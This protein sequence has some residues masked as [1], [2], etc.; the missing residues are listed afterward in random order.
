[1]TDN[2]S[3]ASLFPSADT[4]NKFSTVAQLSIGLAQ[5]AY[6]RQIWAAYNAAPT[7]YLPSVQSSL[8]RINRQIEEGSFAAI[9]AGTRSARI[10][11][12]AT[13]ADRIGVAARPFGGAIMLGENAYDLATY[14]GP[15]RVTRAVGIAADDAVGVLAG[16][17]TVV[18]Y[19]AVFG[20]PAGWAALGI[21]A[22][23]AGAYG[24]WGGDTVRNGV[25]GFLDNPSVPLA[26]MTPMP[27]VDLSRYY[28]A[29]D[30]PSA[31]FPGKF[32][33][34]LGIGAP[35][36]VGGLRSASTPSYGGPGFDGAYGGSYGGQDEGS[37][38][39][40]AQSL[41]AGAY[42][43]PASG[44]PSAS[45]YNYDGSPAYSYSNPYSNSYTA[46]V[47]SPTL[48]LGLGTPTDFA[49]AVGQPAKWATADVY[50]TASLTGLYSGAVSAPRVQPQPAPVAPVQPQYAPLPYY[51]PVPADR[52]SNFSQAIGQ[53]APAL[54][55]FAAGFAPTLGAAA[56]GFFSGIA[57]VVGAFVHDAFGGSS[58]GKTKPVLLDLDGNG[59]SVDTLASSN[60]FLDLD[61]SG[62]MRRTA[63]AGK[64][65]GVL[66][67]DADDNGK[68]SSSKEFAFTE[69]DP[70]ANGD[71]EAL[72]N[73]FDTNANGKLDAG[74]AQWAKFKVMV[75]GQMVSLS[76]L[77]VT[78][79][80]LTAKGSGQ[81]FSDGSAITGTTTFTKSDGTTG[82]VGDAVLSNETDSHVVKNTVVVNADQ[83]STRT[84]V[85]YNADGTLAF[86]SL[87][88]TSADG[89][90]VQ[91][92]FDDDGNG[93][94]DRS[95]TD[96]TTVAAS[97]ERTRVISN[98]N[99]DGSLVERTTTVTS[100]DLKT[101]TTSV[102]N[103][104]DGRDDQTQTFATNADGS[105]MTTTKEFSTSGALLQQKLVQSSADGLT[106]TT[107]TDANGDGVYEAV[108]TETTVIA[109]DGSRTRTVN[110]TSANGT[111]L[112]S[113]TTLTS[114]DGRT[115]T[116]S[117][118]LDGNGTLDD[119]EQTQR[120]IAANGDVTT[121]VTTTNGNGS[122][123]GKVTTVAAADGLS[124]TVSTDLTSDGV[125]DRV[126]SDVTLVAGDGTRTQTVQDTSASGVVLSKSFTTTSVDGKVK[127]ISVD[128]NGDGA[129]DT[130]TTITVASD[131]STSQIDSTLS[132]NGTLVSKALT[133]TSA[134]G[135]SKILSTDLNGDGSFDTV[136]TD[137]ITAGTSG[138]RIETVTRKSANGALIGQTVT[139]TSADSLTQTVQSDRNGDGTFDQTVTDVVTLNA[140]AR[141]ETVTAKSGN[142]T[143]LSQTVTTVSADRKTTSVTKDSDGDGHIDTA[144]T[145]I[146]AADGSQTTTT[147]QGSADGSLHRKT[148]VTVSAD[149]LTTTTTDD[150]NGDGT[151]DVTTVDQTVINADGS[152]TET[153]TDKS[154]TGVLLDKATTVTSGNGLT[155]TVQKDINGDG[156]VDTK[157]VKATVLN[158]DGSKTT[159]TS[160]YAGTALTDQTKVTVSANG[161]V[162]T[163]SYDYDGNATVDRTETA[164]KTL[165][166]D[167]S[168]SLVDAVSTA[169]GT[170]LSKTTNTATADG[171]SLTNQ[172]DLDGDGKIDQKTT[173]VID[174][175]GLTTKTVETY[176]TGT[177]TLASRSVTTTST[178]GLSVM[179]KSD[180]DGDGTFEQALSDVTALNAD[181]SRTET[182]VR[183]TNT[184]SVELTKVTTSANGLIKT[185]VVSDDLIGSA[186]R[187]EIY[188]LYHAILGRDPDASGFQNFS[189]DFNNGVSAVTIA[190]NLLNS[191]EFAQKYGTLTNIQF[192]TLLYQNALGRAPEPGAAEG[193]DAQIKAGTS[194]A[195][196]AQE[197]ADSPEG[198]AHT[199]AGVQA[200]ALNNPGIVLS[201]VRTTTDVTTLGADGSTTEVVTNTGVISNKT[202]T[203]TS[204]DGKTVTVTYDIDGNGVVDQKSVTT[205]NADGSVTQT[206]SDLTSAGAVS[207]SKTV[208]TGAGGF[209]TL[210]S[211]DTDGNGAANKTVS[212]LTTLNADGSKTTVEKTYAL[213]GSGTLVLS[214]TTQT[215]TSADGLTV[216]TKW[217]QTGSGTFT[218]SRTDVTVLNADGSRTETVSYFT[219]TTLTSRYLTKTS[220]EGLSVTTLSDPAGTGVYAQ[221]LKDVTVVNADGTRTRT[222]TSTRSDGS[223]ISTI[224]T[225]TSADGRLLSTNEQR[226][227]LATQTVSDRV[228]MLADGAKRE[229]VTTTDTSGK[230]IDKTIT[231]TS[232]DKQTVTIDRDA[233]GDSVIDQHQQTMTADSG[234]VTQTVTNYKS[235]GVK[236]DGSTSTTT[237]DGLQS[238]TNWD[239]DGNG[240]VDRRRVTVNTNNADG[241]KT[242]VIAD[243]DL[244]TN[245]LASKT[246]IQQS[247]DGMVRTTSKDVDGDG[248]VDQV[249]TLTADTT[250][251]TISIVTNNAIG[252]KADY[253]LAGQ[254]YW[255]QAIAA[256]VETDSSA[257]GRT[258][259]VK[260]DYD[261]NGTFEVVMQSQLQADGSTVATVTETNASGGVIAKGTITTS[262]DGLITVLAKDSTNDGVIDHTETSVIHN[263]GS[264]TLTKVDLN[265]SSA[266]TQTVVDTVSAMG[267]LTLRVTSDGQGRKISQL[268]IAGDG[269]SVTTNYNAAGAQ[270]TS[271]IN[272]NKAGTPTSAVLYDPL[273][274]N[275]WARVEQSFDANG[276]KTFERQF[277][278]DGTRTEVTFYTPTGAQQHVDFFNAA[279]IRTGSIDYDVT[280]SQPWNR[281][282][283][284]FNAAGQ[285]LTE[286]TYIDD[287]SHTVHSFDPTNSQP[288]ANIDQEYNAAGKITLVWQNNDDGTYSVDTYDAGNTAN[289]SR[290]IKYYDAAGR[291]FQEN[292]YMDDGSSGVYNFDVSNTQSW[293]RYAQHFN[294]AGQADYTEQNNDDGSHTT[295][296]YDPTN[297]QSWNRLDQNFNT[298]GQLVSQVAYYDNGT[299]GIWFWDPTNAQSW[300]EIDQSFNTAGQMTNQNVIYDD[301]SKAL[302]A[303]DPGNTQSWSQIVDAYTSSGKLI[304]DTNYSDTNG[305]YTVTTYDVNNN[306]PWTR[307]VQNFVNNVINTATSYND[308]GGYTNYQYDS[309][310]KN[311]AW[312]R[313]AYGTG[314][315]GGSSGLHMVDQWPQAGS[316][317]GGHRPVLLDLNGDGHID[318]RPLDTNALATG[319]SVTFDWNGDGARDGTAWVG[320]Q[321]GFLAI[322]LGEDGQAGWDGKI[323]QSKELA[324]SEWA[325]P[326]QVAASGGSVSDL[327]GLRLAFD[328][329]H[330]NV[331]DASDDRWSEFRVWRDAN[332][333]GAVD[334]GELQTMSEAG[335][336]L[337]N[338]LSTTDSSQSFSD[339]SAITGTSS[340]QTS[341]GASHYLVGDST[342]A[343]QPAIPK[344]NA[345]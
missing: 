177:T 120:T 27:N 103:D 12:L 301:G 181:G 338:L 8:P 337:I 132:T 156:T 172:V 86:Q 195:A 255:K 199:A 248:S 153:V 295:I 291:M 15:S 182:L 14:Q 69:W 85:G 162:T 183:S 94:Y 99:A 33:D 289:W 164:T 45:K 188:R 244:T 102:D 345:A 106:K 240:T 122:L 7:R 226:T 3:S 127:T 269:S 200:W 252:Q 34:D 64:G 277:N 317:G 328:T 61:N 101:I 117:S 273:N 285:L 239:L 97:G 230:L 115:R 300:T 257:D 9:A 24:W 208:T 104:G 29:V 315:G 306:Q 105:S 336:K 215:D 342:L 324:F 92:K 23:G 192:A 197:I 79:I 125:A 253:L 74:D 293:W 1:M 292:D 326:D 129:A 222:Q 221:M 39:R 270:V 223:V 210:V 311:T 246:T 187:S 75:D 232:A 296:T 335:I 229:T 206:S 216:T 251:A 20:T 87:V 154:N 178:N 316:G 60:T 57:G 22:L 166:T 264:I 219:G 290:I 143:L 167:G 234:V 88:A 146:I 287:G 297:A 124:T 121:V 138:A 334:D 78:S 98:F 214:A 95:Q 80:D 139:T 224:M 310:G 65:D 37:R 170:L 119:Q 108:T 281:K 256:K 205:K 19:G 243:T 333:N 83:T 207:H 151:I 161:L 238:T 130:L 209:N 53:F 10:A 174:A 271:V 312:Q 201:P 40:A 48:G 198:Q 298:N 21:G 218:K 343:Y 241:S 51:G 202:T 111:L 320:P 58:S 113:D 126:H 109:S 235:A 258:K 31:P 43:S 176:K 299:K 135:L 193:R 278:D 330:D 242:T 150:L 329:N 81:T 175:T 307:L 190:A 41:G 314:G 4:V 30:G 16:I 159:T 184:A 185:T 247:S 327:D 157:T 128:A 131:G 118:D 344:Q 286:T 261:G 323:D 91:T 50:D 67:F 96:V 267:S 203:T 11:S 249:E 18:A 5:S 35:P 213:N 189:N 6:G 72:R 73:V 66:V 254:V 220:A 313:Y 140:G 42:S 266:V 284:A 288:W 260:Y 274:A 147:V 308:D 305:K 90:T 259:T 158:N 168:T 160:D 280:N 180:L 52:P 225:T 152:R 44:Q 319:S 318:L 340:Y 116:I 309:S 191:P 171:K 282:D 2:K 228:E 331:L 46:G 194:R 62:Y 265:A 303:Y 321:D 59:V 26:M 211:Y 148:V 332:Q 36:A 89:K 217:D 136:L 173:T 84:I 55:T 134:D 142:G 233:N 63:W 231:L 68:I 263:D 32:A 123:R 237:A 77:G 325:T 165:N 304:S 294:S 276:K 133:A 56:V 302:Y 25:T 114:A 38:A 169:G 283:D 70:S 227:G 137:V 262:T 155:I 186:T 112:S 163:T 47:Y 245:K 144:S 341:D 272:A 110:N 279:G 149:K 250:G 145:Q 13:V 275:P 49:P 339:G 179:T 322:D 82:I 204:G 28:M 76:S 236:A 107:K 100:A 93:T 54:G 212:D 71:L 141:T 268:V 17:G 196:V